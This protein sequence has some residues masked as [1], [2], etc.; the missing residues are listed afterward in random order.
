MAHEWDS[1][2]YMYIQQLSAAIA[3]FNIIPCIQA[4]KG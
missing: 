1:K 3:L 2:G 4:A